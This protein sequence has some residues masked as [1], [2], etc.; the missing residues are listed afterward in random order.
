MNEKFSRFLRSRV[1]PLFLAGRG[2]FWL[3][4]VPVINGEFVWGYALEWDCFVRVRRIPFV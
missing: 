4:R 3:L 2:D 1:I